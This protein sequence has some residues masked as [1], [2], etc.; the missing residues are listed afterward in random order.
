[1]NLV[2]LASL[3][4]IN[5]VGLMF[6][7]VRI[8]VTAWGR[9][10]L[11][12]FAAE[13]AAGRVAAI[14]RAM[15]RAFVAT[16]FGSVGW[17]LVLWLAWH[18]IDKHFLVGQYP[19]AWLLVWPW[20]I[21]TA[22]DAM[23]HIVSIALRAAREFKFLAFGMMLSAPI[24]VAATAGAVWWQGYTWTMYGFAFGQFVMLAMEIVRFYYVR[25]RVAG[26]GNL[27]GSGRALPQG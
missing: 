10:A 8:M 25:R 20:A 19:D 5:V 27:D 21:A 11:P 7:P 2:G 13:L 22:L 24:T 16:A 23:S 1:V 12:H 17:M 3:A 18:Q 4:A 26:S 15:M 14:D 9:T 6:R